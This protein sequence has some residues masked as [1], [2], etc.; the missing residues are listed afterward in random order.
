VC[1]IFNF[2]LVQKKRT[3]SFSACGV[4]L[5]QPFC[6]SDLVCFLTLTYPADSRHPTKKHL[7][8]ASSAIFLQAHPTL[9]TVVARCDDHH[10]HGTFFAI[11][12]YRLSGLLPHDIVSKA[13]KSGYTSYCLPPDQLSSR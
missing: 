5:E 4:V 1:F 11:F 12:L 8:A 6:E 7:E 10:A 9:K 2:T 3:S 13:Q